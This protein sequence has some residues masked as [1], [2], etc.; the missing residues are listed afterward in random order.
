MSFPITKCNKITEGLLTLSA[1]ILLLIALIPLIMVGRYAHPWADDYSYCAYTNTTWQ[2]SH[3][4]GVVLE[5]AFQKVKETYN[6]WQGTFASAFLMCLCP[7]IWGEEMYA[8]T[9]VIMLSS[10]VI[11][12]FFLLYVVLV[13]WLKVC[14]QQ[15][16]YISCIFTFW[17]LQTIHSP[18]N[19]L[20][21]YNGSVHYTFMHGVMLVTIALICLLFC[22]KEW[23]A[24]L[25]ITVLAAIASVICSG[26]NYSTALL[27]ML[28]L[29]GMVVGFQWY[30]KKWNY[31]ANFPL[32]SYGIGFYINITAPGN[33][34]RQGHFEG[35]G[36]L[37]S[38]WSSFEVSIEFIGKW[39]DWQTCIILLLIVP[40]VWN[41][42][43]H[44]ISE[45]EYNFSM[46]GVVTVL[47]FGSLA[48]MFTPLFYAMGGAGVDR[49]TNIAKMWF[50]LLVLGNFIYW[51]GWVC[52][53]FRCRNFN[54]NYISYHSGYFVVVG[55]LLFCHFY[56][57]ED[58]LTDYTS[59]AAYVSLKTG[60]AK[61]FYEEYVARVALLE[62]DKEVIELQPYTIRPY[63]LY[64]EDITTDKYDWKNSALA[65][66][67]GKKSVYLIE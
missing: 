22:V 53:K 12:H 58:V 17:L 41:M 35:Q 39:F 4:I 14:K 1:T 62:S 28:C 15:W 36:I 43:E 61:N 19:A 47:S 10:I 52:R 63:L 34:M 18:V 13:K 38:V 44:I 66:W 30:Q 42:T 33:S 9:P 60:E 27:G 55:L 23:R 51:I 3:S 6:T 16:W 49:Q 56:L 46:P 7:I 24:K 2:N 32:L 5:A 64:F 50:Q 37:E 45:T 31:W 26:S 21:W 20:Y 40:V 65:S 8:L 48:C 54:V 59:Y 57:C 29:L 67:Y 25:L 11:S